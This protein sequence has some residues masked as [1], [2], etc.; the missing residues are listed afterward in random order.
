MR[1]TIA[2]FLGHRFLA[3]TW[4]FVPF[5]VLYMRAEGMAFADV[6]LANVVFCVAALALEIPT[7]VF[8]DR[9]GRRLA[10]GLGGIVMAAAC[11]LFLVGHTVA[12]FA[13]AN[14]LAATSMTLVSGAD[15]AYLYDQLVA[16]GRTSEY[17]AIEGWATAVKG[18]GNVLG[19][20]LGGAIFETHPG[21]VFG[22]TAIVS[23]GATVMAALLPREQ[24]GPGPRS[25][26]VRRSFR[27]VRRSRLLFGLI[28][29]SA[30]LF[31]PL[32]LGLFTDSPHLLEMDPTV[33]ALAMGAL[34]AAK[35]VAS[36]LCALLLVPVTRRLG[37]RNVL[38]LL[39][40]GV[41]LATT[42]MGLAHGWW[43]LPLIIVLAG[44]FG[45]YSPA[46]RAALNSAIRSS[47]DRAT[48]LSIE[49]MARRAGFAALS[50][51]FGAAV[52]T[53]SLNAALLLSAGATLLALLPVA[54]L[55]RATPEPAR[56]PEIGASR[57]PFA[58]HPSAAAARLS[59][60]AGI[61][62]L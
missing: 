33:G 24:L 30:L 14:V 15:S 54:G 48:V 56:A 47:R 27:A 55:L 32:R 53:I 2:L 46:L 6:M 61:A 10:L 58:V 5:Q 49:G 62:E 4:V 29:Y 12:T 31:V 41:A 1:R 51:L 52:D 22:A 38:L 37:E 42:W 26:D 7:G 25:G 59:Q 20:L 45:F 39:P 16:A 11:G 28:V 8:A 35:D 44:L 9:F 50:P 34:F 19:F 40:L 43:C 36:A 3:L 23:L 18:S 13:W 60:P 17:R 21:W 57:P